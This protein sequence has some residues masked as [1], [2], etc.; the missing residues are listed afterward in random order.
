[1]SGHGGMSPRGGLTRILVA[2]PDAPEADAGPASSV[3]ERAPLVAEDIERIAPTA[4][5][6]ADGAR[7]ATPPV[8]DAD[9]D[10]TAAL[11]ART[12]LQRILEAFAGAAP[13]GGARTV[14]ERD[15]ALRSLESL[16]AA[17][18]DRART[19]VCS[20]C[21][22]PR[23]RRGPA[24]SSRLAQTTAML[25]VRHGCSKSASAGAAC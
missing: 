14:S 7:V 21:C 12:A 25:G 19:L 17:R 5:G 6:T 23:V 9:G 10:G 11:T 24:H 8:D 18:A 20:R 16:L 2:S 3:V 1:M 4:V 15:A 13:T 22:S